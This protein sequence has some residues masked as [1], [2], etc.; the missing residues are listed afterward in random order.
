[1][2]KTNFARVAALVA[3]VAA[4]STALAAGPGVP[5]SG[6]PGQLKAAAV[7]TKHKLLTTYIDSNPFS[8]LALPAATFVPIGSV[9]S[10]T[11]GNTAGCTLG[12]EFMAQIAPTGADNP[13]AICIN[14]DNA[15][16][17]CPW[18]A[19]IP[20]A[21]SIYTT[22][23][24]RYNFPVALGAHTMQMVLYTSGASTLGAYESTFRVYKP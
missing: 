6:G 10:M 15:L 18:V 5:G 23:N 13:W 24:T 11:C 8:G 3:F 1:M 17:Y 9:A 16:Q 20:A 21:L 12:A 4:T 7:T 14:V 19:S 2:H 22:E